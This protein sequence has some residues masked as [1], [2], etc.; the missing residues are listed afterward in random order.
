MTM[1]FRE[2][3][4]RPSAITLDGCGGLSSRWI[5]R[6]SP[7]RRYDT[8]GLPVAG[9]VPMYA[10]ASIATRFSLARCS[11]NKRW[12]HLGHET[13]HLLFHLG[14][15]LQADIEVEDHLIESGRLD[16]FECLGDIGAAA[17]E[18]GVLRQVLRAQIAEPVHHAH[19]VAIA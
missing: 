7:M 4:R 15:R 5:N 8:M 1:R 9:T 6:G 19:K 3:L 18:D 10:R 14:V 11:G 2:R 17:K 16:A 12:R 13:G